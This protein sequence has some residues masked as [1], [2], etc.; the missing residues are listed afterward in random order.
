[1]PSAERLLCKF[2]ASF[3]AVMAAGITDA[4]AEV[5]LSIGRTYSG[6]DCVAGYIAIN[7]RIV[8]YTLEL[9]W[10]DNMESNS[11]IPIH[12]YKATIRDDGKLGWRVQ[13]EGVPGPRE[14]IQI[15]I[16]SETRHTHGCILVGSDTGK[17]VCTLKQGSS[18]E[19]LDKIR[20]AY[21]Q[22]P[23][24]DVETGERRLSVNVTG[25]TD[26][27]YE[28]EQVRK[29]RNAEYNKELKSVLKY[30]SDLHDGAMRSYQDQ[31]AQ[32]FRDFSSRGIP[33][34]PSSSKDD[35]KASPK[36]A[37][38]GNRKESGPTKQT[39]KQS[40]DYS[41]PVGLKQPP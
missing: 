22:L 35:P 7:D 5:R 17:D 11:A 41:P 29:A 30:K 2:L 14:W 34:M 33:S 12:D 9:P 19:I 36:S 8:G 37:N 13:L 23:V 18:R 27:D 32:K 16:G 25:A 6:P 24:V 15:H 40:S 21:D 39:T 31:E 20:A 3:C 28:L 26:I 10:N 4:A 1:M 38:S